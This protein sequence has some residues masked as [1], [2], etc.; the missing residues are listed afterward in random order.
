MMWITMKDIQRIFKE[1]PQ[2]FSTNDVYRIR[3]LNPRKP[4]YYEN[5]DTVH[6]VFAY[7]YSDCVK[8]SI[9][10]NDGHSVL[11]REWVTVPIFFDPLTRKKVIGITEEYLRT[12]ILNIIEQD[13]IKTLKD[14][15]KKI[16]R[17]FK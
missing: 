5:S 15:I 2:I 6:T 14:K 3:Q 12:L 16:K 7:F 11:V 13:K 1:Y 8:I 10:L 4:E 17:D 9:K